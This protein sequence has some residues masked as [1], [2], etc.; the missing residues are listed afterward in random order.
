MLAFTPPVSALASSIEGCVLSLK[1]LSERFAHAGPHT[2]MQCCQGTPLCETSTLQSPVCGASQGI[3][4]TAPCT[5]TL[6]LAATPVLPDGHARCSSSL[7][8][9]C[10]ALS[11]AHSRQL[12]PLVTPK[13]CHPQTPSASP[14]GCAPPSASSTPGRQQAASAGHTKLQLDRSVGRP[15]GILHPR[16]DWRGFRP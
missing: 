6:V 2:A 9:A 4:M 15:S 14:G 7:V 8:H 16:M 10:H 1:L 13:R 3:Y 12:S 11:P 5:H